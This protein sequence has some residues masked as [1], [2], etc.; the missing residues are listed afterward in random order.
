MKATRSAFTL[1]ELLVVIAII[2]ILAA[3]LFPVFAQAKVAAKKTVSISNMSQTVLGAAMYENDY[4][5]GL[6]LADT[7]CITP[8]QA[9]CVGWGYGPPDTV[10]AEAMFPYIKNFDITIDPMS[11]LPGVANREQT[12]FS[13]IGAPIY[14][15]SIA[16]GTTAELQYAVGARSNVA[17]NFGFFS[18]W[19]IKPSGGGTYLGSF[20]QS[21]TEITQPA[22]TLMFAGPSVWNTQNG[23]PTGG[24]NWVVQTPCWQDANGNY[25]APLGGLASSGELFSYG[26]GWQPIPGHWDVYGGLWPFYTTSNVDAAAAAQNGQVIV[27]FADSHVKS[28]AISAVAAGCSAYGETALKG[29]VTDPSKFIWNLQQ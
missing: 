4:D 18:P 16:Q 21:A 22:H 1:I 20:S 14:P 9:N 11:D 28:M 2:A 3:I 8:N 5:D 27:G 17:Y 26:S 12:Q 24:G 6:P 23:V 15:P 10:P 7:G 13:Y 29:T 19:I 25:L